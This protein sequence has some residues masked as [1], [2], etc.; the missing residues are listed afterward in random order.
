ATRNW[1]GLP[2]A[3]GP[4]LA[5]LAAVWLAGRLLPLAPA[6]PGVLV[7]AVDLSFL[8]LLALALAV[9]V[10]RAQH[11][12]SLMFP[13]LLLVLTG[14]NLAIHLER[15]GV[16]EGVARP[17]LYAGVDLVVIL[18]ALMGGRVIP[19][20]TEKALEGVR[21]RTW[22]WVERAAIPSIAILA[23][24]EAF[25]PQP[26]VVGGL[27]TV[28]AVINGI[29][30]AGWLDRKVWSVPLLWVLHL[31]Y[32]WLVVGFAMKAVAAFGGVSP[33]LALH[34]LT[35]GGIGGATLGMMARV[36]LG[37]TGRTLDL[38]AG[39]AVAFGLL[40]IAAAVRVLL[41]L[42]VPTAYAGLIGLSGAL[43]SLAFLIF[44]FRYTPILYRPRIDGR[45]G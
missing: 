13:V 1:T 44:V 38:P 40:H 34:A 30:F 41:P 10:V 6:L 36:S 18:I 9:P 45:P 8:P 21:P 7:A 27:A 37:H 31:A 2:T 32:G 26:A 15:L 5:G 35:A 24:A 43:W 17:A 4:V 39:M 19:F 42:A 33:L 29:R 28:A 23:L 3:R 22:P 12:K 16:A 11:W 20:F 25:Y 14:A